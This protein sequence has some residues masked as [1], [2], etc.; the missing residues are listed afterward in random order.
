MMMRFALLPATLT[1]VL[2]LAPSAQ[3]EPCTNPLPPPPI[4]QYQHVVSANGI[5]QMVVRYEANGTFKYTYDFRIGSTLDSTAVNPRSV[6]LTEREVTGIWGIDCR[7]FWWIKANGHKP[8]RR[9]AKSNGEY[10]GRPL[11][12]IMPPPPQLSQR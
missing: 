7:T 8:G 1:F 5:L 11:Q 10:I 12:A 2:A 3:A 9:L 4:G 6:A